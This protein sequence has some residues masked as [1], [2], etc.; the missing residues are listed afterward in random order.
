LIKSIFF[1]TDAGLL[2]KMRQVE[3]LA[4]I[5]QLHVGNEGDN[6]SDGSRSRKDPKYRRNCITLDSSDTG[7][8]DISFTGTS[9]GSPRNAAAC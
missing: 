1:R 8:H 4:D 3:A 2:K 9:V 7:P 6:A 5:P